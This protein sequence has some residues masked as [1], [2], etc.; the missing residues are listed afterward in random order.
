MTD[1]IRKRAIAEVRYDKLIERLRARKEQCAAGPWRTDEPPRDGRTFLMVNPNGR[2]LV[3]WWSQRRLRW[4]NESHY[5]ESRDDIAA[6]API[7]MPKEG[8]Q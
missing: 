4:V 5:S 8:G 3:V 1:H 2:A 6:W 7:N